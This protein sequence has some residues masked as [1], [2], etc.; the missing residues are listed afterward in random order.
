MITYDFLKLAELYKKELKKIHKMSSEKIEEKYF[1]IINSN[2][3]NEENFKTIFN[4]LNKIIVTLKLDQTNNTKNINT[5]IQYILR[6]NKIKLEIFNDNK[7]KKGKRDTNNEHLKYL[8]YNKFKLIRF[9]S[10]GAFGKVYLV[11]YNNKQYAVKEQYSMNHFKSDLSLKFIKDRLNEFRIAKRLA[12]NN[13]GPK[14]Y[15]N[16]FIFDEQKES[17][18]NLILMEYIDGPTLGDY[19]KNHRLTIKQIDDLD[20]IIDKVHSLKIFHHDLHIN[21]ILVKKLKK[22]IKFYIIDTGL[23]VNNKSNF[24]NI[25]NKFVIEQLKAKDFNPDI[26]LPLYNIITNGKVKIIL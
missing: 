12:Q 1:D 16:I 11:K 7:I 20:K 17:Y 23:A 6:K 10:A 9:I 13:I 5:Q 24:K 25:R 21:N 15:K 8:K 14:M 18:I 3:F 26:L 22:G 4:I 19:K 2:E